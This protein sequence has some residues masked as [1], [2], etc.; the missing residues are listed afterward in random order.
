MNC[1]NNLNVCSCDIV[2]CEQNL[3]LYISKRNEIDQMILKEQ[4]LLYE[5]DAASEAFS[6]L[7][8]YGE[9]L[10]EDLLYLRECSVPAKI[11]GY[12][13]DL[14]GGNWLKNYCQQIQP[15]EKIIFV[16]SNFG[17]GNCYGNN[18]NLLQCVCGIKFSY[19][20]RVYPGCVEEN[21]E[22]NHPK[23]CCAEYEN[24]KH[25]KM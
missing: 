3:D 9:S 12:G 19:K 5:I 24:I 23:F 10:K 20:V 21:K 25:S 1:N 17:S 18:E 7:F 8:E 13:Y 6:D 2:V 15:W 14:N 22:F 11:I 16:P 4:N